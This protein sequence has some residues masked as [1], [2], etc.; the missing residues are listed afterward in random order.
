ML[1][2]GT[3]DVRR[4]TFVHKGRSL[5]VGAE[6]VLV[7]LET[8]PPPR[9]SRRGPRRAG[10]ELVNRLQPDVAEYVANLGKCRYR[11]GLHREARR[12]RDHAFALYSVA[13]RDRPI[14]GLA[15]AAMV[16]WRLGERD[17]AR[18]AMRDL[19]S[20]VAASPGNNPPEVL[21]SI[22]EARALVREPET[23]TF[24]GIPSFGAGSAMTE[25]RE[26]W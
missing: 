16:D 24:G 8:G 12:S 23:G 4:L 3:K 11:A 19:E 21:P 15:F 2:A 14:E 7:L 9:A 17:A 5:L 25:E 26:G 18:E 13:G 6:R 1:D 10:L 20:R 22:Q